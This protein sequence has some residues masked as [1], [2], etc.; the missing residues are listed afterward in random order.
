MR[1]VI[2]GRR[3]TAE[4]TGVGRYLESLLAGWAETGPPLPRMLVVLH[5]PSGLDRVPRCAGMR[6]EVVG[7]GWPGL[8]WERFGL[9]R[10]LRSGDLLFAPT[11]LIP[12]CWRGPT[13]LVLFDT[14][15]EARPDDFPRLVHWRFRR[16]YRQAARRA[17]RLIVPSEATGRDAVRWLGVD[18]RRIRPIYPGVEPGFAPLPAD[19]PEVRSARSALGLGSDPFFLFVG[20]RSRRRHVPSLLAAFARHRREFPTHRLVFAGPAD[21]RLDATGVVEAGHVAEPVLRALMAT[22]LGLLYPSEYEGF[23]LPVVEAMACGCPVVTLRRGAL[24]ESGGDAA[25]FLDEADPDSLERAMNRLACDPE[26]RAENIARGRDQ[27]ARFGR[28]EFA[29]RVAR[30]IC[31][32]AAGVSPP[33]RAR[34]SGVSLVVRCRGNR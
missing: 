17:D 16:R 18:P 34:R 4:R 26:A 27:A 8:V 14:L 20:K 25:L 6:A 22:A 15:L 29:A 13:V 24:L 10:R 21:G 12:D 9:G 31:A 7:A 33:N 2:D 1:L 19:A 5:D 23:G 3:L 28:R 11:N 30:E 32:V